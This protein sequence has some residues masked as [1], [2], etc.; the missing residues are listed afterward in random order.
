MLQ[1]H[2][3]DVVRSI[4]VERMTVAHVYANKEEVQSWVRLRLILADECFPVSPL[5]SPE[6]DLKTANHLPVTCCAHDDSLGLVKL[7]VA[8]HDLENLIVV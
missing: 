4:N 8:V 5:V 1:S 3:L 6:A 2:L 7:A